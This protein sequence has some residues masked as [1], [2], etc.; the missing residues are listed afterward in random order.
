MTDQKLTGR[1][2]YVC[3]HKDHEGVLRIFLAPG[4][5][6]PKKCPMGH[7]WVRQ[8][9]VPYRGGVTTPTNA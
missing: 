9:N 5:A 7:P 4:E 2:A 6:A 8:E 1:R 3:T